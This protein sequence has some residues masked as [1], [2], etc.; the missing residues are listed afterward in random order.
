M[1]WKAEA[2]NAVSARHIQQR[3]PRWKVYAER[4]LRT[5]SGAPAAEIRTA[6][7]AGQKAPSQEHHG[8]EIPSTI[9]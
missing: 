5:T 4:L 7:T 2:G 3:I 8:L 1:L 6:I 9:S